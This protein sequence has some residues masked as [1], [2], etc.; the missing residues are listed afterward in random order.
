MCEKLGGFMEALQNQVNCYQYTDYMLLEEHS[1]HLTP[2]GA[3]SFAHEVQPQDL[4]VE[5]EK[6]DDCVIL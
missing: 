3:V 4:Q 1:A 6:V 2:E 5:I